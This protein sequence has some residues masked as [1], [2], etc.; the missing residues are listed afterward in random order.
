MEGKYQETDWAAAAGEEVK[1]DK[2][3]RGP[4]MWLTKDHLE[5]Q[6]PTEQEQQET[7]ISL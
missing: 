4:I 7:D 1:Q 3:K 5:I 2:L 6:D